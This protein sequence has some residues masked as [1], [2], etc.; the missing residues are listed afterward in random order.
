MMATNQIEEIRFALE[1]M[2]DEGSQSEHS[3]GCGRAEG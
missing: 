1:S 2:L 3:D